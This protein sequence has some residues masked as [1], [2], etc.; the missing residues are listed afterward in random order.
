MLARA[1]AGL[2][3]LLAPLCV[4]VLALGSTR[5]DPFAFLSPDLVVS[6]AERASL[7]RGETLVKVLPGRDGYLALSAIVKIDA[8]ADRVVAWM[9][10]V[11]RTQRGKYV[12][13]IGRFS[14]A[15]QLDD[16]RGLTL[17]A[18][19]LEELRRCRPGDCGV[20]VS[21]R[22]LAHLRAIGDSAAL[23]RAFRQILVSRAA[24]YLARGDECAP[25]Y[26]DHKTP[27]RPADAFDAVLE[28]LPFL[29]RH[30][31]GYAAYLKRYPESPDGLVRQSFLYWSKETL[32]MKPIIAITHFSVIRAGDPALPEAMIVSKQIYATHYRNASISLTAVAGD[33]DSRYLVYV[34]RAQIDAFR[35]MLG[36]FVRR[37]VE[38]RVRAEAP[39]VLADLRRRMESPLP[40]STR[41]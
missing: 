29:R 30:F 11:E 39:G 12:A 16:L 27:I 4:G 20:K 40:L 33:G 24:D 19:D 3:T 23:E 35:G 41:D 1:L 26:H 5:L 38:R 36:G 37:V 18:E 21:A 6:P 31:A 2:L 10:D 9:G 28:R 25:P 17:P 32:G 22:E 7:D 8:P 14:A 34:N 13:E 15:P